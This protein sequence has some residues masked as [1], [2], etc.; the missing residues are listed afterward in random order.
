MNACEGFPSTID[1]HFPAYQLLAS[2]QELLLNG[3]PILVSQAIPEAHLIFTDAFNKGAV[4]IGPDHSKIQCFWPLHKGS[5]QLK[6]LFAIYQ[7]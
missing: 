6:E 2:F 1:N 5:I 3:P 7:G 4:S